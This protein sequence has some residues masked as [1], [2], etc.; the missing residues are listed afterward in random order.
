MVWA[1]VKETN[2]ITWAGNEQL[3]MDAMSQLFGKKECK[4]TFWWLIVHGFFRYSQ[5]HTFQYEGTHR[6][7]D[8][9]ELV[10]FSSRGLAFLQWLSD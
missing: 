3:F 8:N 6:W 10:T 4:N 9:L 7:E 2:A 5:I 1:T